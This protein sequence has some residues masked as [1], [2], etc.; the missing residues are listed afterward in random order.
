MFWI[1][2]LD[3]PPMLLK[4]VFI[5]WFVMR[6]QQCVQET[7]KWYPVSLI[8]K[9]V[10]VDVDIYWSKEP[11]CCPIV[12][13]EI[14]FP[15]PPPLYWFWELA[16][17]DIVQDP[18]VKNGRAK[19]LPL[20]TE[21]SCWLEVMRDSLKSPLL[22]TQPIWDKLVPSYSNRHLDSKTPFQKWHRLLE[23]TLV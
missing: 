19:Q 4:K 18:E 7:V 6:Y 16:K 11:L 20:F 15:G 3:K 1:S 5:L 9:R 12:S 8:F 2:K 22:E 10:R 14:W 23:I 13:W 21:G 17:S